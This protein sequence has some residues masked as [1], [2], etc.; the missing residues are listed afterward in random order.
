MTTRRRFVQGV[1]AAS[2][3]APAV[4]ARPGFGQSS[5]VVNV[6]TWGDY[7]QP[8]MIERFEG[9]TGI[10]LNLSTYGSNNELEQKIRAAGGEG[11][12]VIFPSVTNVPNY[13]EGEAS[14]L[15]PIDE[16][17]VKTSNLIPSMYRD[18]I[19]L[20]AVRRGERMAV[21]FNW[22]TEGITYDETVFP[23]TAPGDVSYAMLWDERARDRAAFRQWSV[24][25]GTGL[26]LDAIG[27]I[28]SNR[29]ADVYRS[30]E[31]M[32]RVFDQVSAFVM[33]RRD[34]FGAFWNNATEAL[35]A[36]QQAGCVVGQTWDS[37]GLLLNRDEPALLYRMP[38][39]GG[40]TWM[41]SMA[42]PVGAEH[43]DE[44]Y[45]F[46]NAMLEPEMAGLMSMNTGYNSCVEGAAAHA[47]E[48]Y[49]RQFAEVYTAENLSQLWWWPAETPYFGPVRQEY[50]D[51]ITNAA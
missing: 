45:A 29:M 23:D 31:D 38:K 11:F 37:T 39:E 36:F 14:L 50:V 43:L 2:L 16:G 28:E 19:Q 7:L 30:E 13:A 20:G 48:V 22:G 47:G 17:R 46:L 35:N 44:A 24:L 5:G 25:I 32:R 15:Q 10:R 12:D 41:D 40:I 8:N 21:P 9:Q 27:E 6:F 42:I 3:A 4:L 33:E 18:S 26:Y 34:N 51:R 1:A 49:A